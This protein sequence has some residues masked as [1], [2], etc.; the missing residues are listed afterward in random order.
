MP[1]LDWPKRLKIAI[2]SAKGL[3][4]LHAWR[5]YVFLSLLS[6]NRLCGV[7]FLSHFSFEKKAD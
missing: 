3:A 4:Y 7:Q 6:L 1:V 2:G 5:L